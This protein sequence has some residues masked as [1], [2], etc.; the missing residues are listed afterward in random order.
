MIFDRARSWCTSCIRKF[1]ASLIDG[2]VVVFGLGC[3]VRS[4]MVKVIIDSVA[5]RER[6]DPFYDT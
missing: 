1:G 4:L 2:A 3:S 6:D 5:G